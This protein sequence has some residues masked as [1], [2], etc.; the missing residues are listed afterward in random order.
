MS[1]DALL[2]IL[3]VEIVE[4][5]IYLMLAVSAV[6]FVWGVF[7]F[8]RTSDSEDGRTTGKKHMVYGIIG[9][10]IMLAVTGIIDLIRNT[11]GG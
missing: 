7:Q 2:S 10:A 4:P 8:V 11:V 3:E 5:F 1:P 9:L 6:Y